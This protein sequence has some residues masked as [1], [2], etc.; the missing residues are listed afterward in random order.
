MEGYFPDVFNCCEL[1]FSAVAS[2]I[3][4]RNHIISLR[5]QGAI[6]RSLDGVLRLFQTFEPSAV[7]C[8]ISRDIKTRNHIVSLHQLGRFFEVYRWHYPSQS[9][10][11]K[12][13]SLQF[14]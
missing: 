11:F 14:F 3:K 8:A 4:T 9:D 6:V 10:Y 1:M 12:L 2:D 7:F 5:H 13:L